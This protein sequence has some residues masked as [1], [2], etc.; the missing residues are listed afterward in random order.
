MYFV[1]IIIVERKSQGCSDDSVVKKEYCR[2]LVSLEKLQQQQ[3]LQGAVFL[4]PSCPA[5]LDPK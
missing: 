3:M 2:V 1:L 5:S 4:V